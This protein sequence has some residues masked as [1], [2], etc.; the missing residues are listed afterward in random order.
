[1][2]STPKHGIEV[3]DEDVQREIDQINAL[4]ANLNEEEEASWLA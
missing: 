4:F 1:M 2:A 3:S